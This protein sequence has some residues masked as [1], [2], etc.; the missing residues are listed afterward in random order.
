MNDNQ[1]KLLDEILDTGKNP[2]CLHALGQSLVDS[3]CEI[4][5]EQNSMINTI[6]AVY[7]LEKEIDRQ[8]RKN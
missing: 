5:R 7:E 3:L 8:K 2:V 6:K 1:K 4:I